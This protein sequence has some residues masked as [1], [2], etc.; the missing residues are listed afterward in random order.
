MSVNIFKNGILSK[1]AG[2][3]GDA[4]PLINNFLTNQAGK[5][6]ADANT[7]YVL[8]NKIEELNS[9][10]GDISNVGNDT[11]NSVEKLLQ[12]YIDN[13]YLPDIN[14]IALIPVMTSNTTPSGVAFAYSEF[15]PAYKAFNNTNTGVQENWAMQGDGTNKAYIGYKFDSAKTVK[16]L[17]IQNRNE[18]NSRAVK[19]FILQGTN[20]SSYSSGWV[21]ITTCNITDSTQNHETIFNINNEND[22]IAYRLFI[23]EVYDTNYCGF[24]KIQMYGY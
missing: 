17:Y 19:Q 5:G 24:G 2:A 20:D 6:A 23:T 10:L 14:S 13:G 11:Y 12:Y 15:Y 18:S 4:V 21:D 22:Y 8:N 3:V 1:I 7:V 16:R 9:N